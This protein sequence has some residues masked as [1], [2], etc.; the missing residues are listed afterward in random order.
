M[1]FR[2]PVQG[3]VDRSVA[4]P[5]SFVLPSESTQT[6]SRSHFLRTSLALAVCVVGLMIPTGAALAAPRPH[7]MKVYVARGEKAV[8]ATSAQPSSAGPQYGLFTCQ[9]VG[10]RAS[11]CLDP[12][13]VRHA[14]GVDTL[15]AEGYDGRGQT[16]VI[17]DAYQNPSLAT[18]MATFDTFYGLPDVQLTLLAPDGLTPFDPTDATMS[19][20][21]E[22]ISLDVEWAHAIAP[23]ARIVLVQAKSSNDPDIISAV[24][25]AVTNELGSVISMS[26]GENESCLGPDLTAEYHNLFAAAT[27]KNITLFASAGDQGA[28]QMTCDGNSWVKAVSSPANDPLVSSVGGTELTVAKYCL[29]SQG[30]DPTQNPAAGT[31]LSETAWN[32]GL[33]YGDYGDIFGYGTLSGGGG[34]SIIFGEPSYQQYVLPDGKQR[35]LPDVAYNAAVEHGVLTYL[36][37]PGIQS[38]FYTF[39]GTSAGSPQWSAI[40][41]IAN[42]RA[43]KSLGFLN[44]GLYR[45][46]VKRQF[47]A[48]SF[49][50][51]TTGTNSSLQFDSLGNPVNIIGFDAGI[52]WDPVTG[53]GTPKVAA[54]V[55][56]L[57][58]LVSPGDG[59]AAIATIKLN[60]NGNANAT[61]A[62]AAKRS[63]KPH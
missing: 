55:D 27:R 9:L 32:E 44:T 58:R 39:G 40:T 34:F 12:Y 45:V 13:E 29:A 57:I 63:V 14:Y 38:G 7:R 37:I 60:A 18:Q 6:A 42:Q 47:Y 35:G 62:H 23:G 43:G 31:Y 33:P 48:E 61:A 53:L 28:A 46:A 21:A 11:N 26:F 25:Y 30:C 52:G 3:V 1:E 17:V 15:I 56:D 4:S 51:I 49:H 16:I 22:E 5:A 2:P 10:L 36:A 54:L 41:A 8:A 50:D 59:T 19:G 20:W 24:N